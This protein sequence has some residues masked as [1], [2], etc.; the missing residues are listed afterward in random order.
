MKDMIYET[1]KILQS[2]QPSYIYQD[3][4]DGKIKSRPLQ[5][6]AGAS[7]HINPAKLIHDSILQF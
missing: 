7:V 1:L 6:S 3:K 4:T 5:D 2:K